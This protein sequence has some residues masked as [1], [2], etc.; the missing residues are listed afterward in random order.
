MDN[1]AA[2]NQQIDEEIMSLYSRG[3]EFPDSYG[4]TSTTKRSP[5]LSTP[6][7][8]MIY[9]YVCPPNHDAF[10]FQF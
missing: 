4:K 1:A 10:W 2:V 8:F 3:F 5:S 9:V 6:F 7:S